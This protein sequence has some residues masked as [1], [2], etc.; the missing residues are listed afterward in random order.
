VITCSGWVFD[1]NAR[2]YVIA[3]EGQ[4]KLHRTI[5]VKADTAS[6]E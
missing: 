1:A 2:K 3:N 5:I 4:A 6:P